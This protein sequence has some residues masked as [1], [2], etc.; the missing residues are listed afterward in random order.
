M[1]NGRLS[2]RACPQPRSYLPE[3]RLRSSSH[4]CLVRTGRLPIQPLKFTMYGPGTVLAIPRPFPASG[5]GPIFGETAGRKDLTKGLPAGLLRQRR[6]VAPP[7][8]QPEEPPIGG[9]RLQGG[10]PPRLRCH[11]RPRSLFLVTR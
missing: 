9:I 7:H 4:V 11:Q 10:H 1:K 6:R 5:S 2:S 8:E 3:S